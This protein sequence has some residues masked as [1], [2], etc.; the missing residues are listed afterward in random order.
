MSCSHVD[1]VLPPFPLLKSCLHV[2]VLPPFPLLM[3]CSHVDVLP[4]SLRGRTLKP[5]V[6]G[7]KTCCKVVTLTRL[8]GVEV[9]GEVV[10][11]T[12]RPGVAWG[13]GTSS[14]GI[15][16]KIITKFSVYF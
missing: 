15:F 8:P 12:S 16:D 10:P 11:L 6:G 7:V 13:G 9:P 5:V 4:L 14:D 2:V 3:S 1:V